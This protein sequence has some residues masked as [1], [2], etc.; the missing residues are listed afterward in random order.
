M[1]AWR[2][3]QDPAMVPDFSIGAGDKKIAAVVEG[4]S[5]REGSSGKGLLHSRR[6]IFGDSTA[7]IGQVP[8]KGNI[9][10]L[11]ASGYC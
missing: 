9:Q 4:D 2:E 11:G 5:P 1:S 10:V 6:R 8:L 7:L 3:F